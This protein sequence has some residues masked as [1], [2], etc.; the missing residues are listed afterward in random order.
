MTFFEK[1]IVSQAKEII[2]KLREN[3]T[4][5]NASNEERTVIYIAANIL[6]EKNKKECRKRKIK[7]WFNK[8]LK[9]A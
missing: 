5:E 8:I 4:V 2:K 3:G 6:K 1:E 9:R 7:E